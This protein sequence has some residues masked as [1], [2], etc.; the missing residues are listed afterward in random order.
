MA[1]EERMLEAPWRAS[2]C[3]P[4]GRLNWHLRTITVQSITIDHVLVLIFFFGIQKF[5]YILETE[6]NFKLC[7]NLRIANELIRHLKAFGR[8][9]HSNEWKRLALPGNL[10]LHLTI[11]TH[12]STGTPALS[13]GI[14]FWCWKN[15][16][17]IERRKHT[18]VHEKPLPQKSLVVAETF[19]KN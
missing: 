3:L 1:F 4:F 2:K 7:A 12:F 19:K 8:C 10:S 18:H 11:C 15:L 6:S 13:A 5:W 9:E 16:S 17:H 14:F